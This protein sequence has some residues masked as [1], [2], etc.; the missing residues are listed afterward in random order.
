MSRAIAL[1][2]WG[3]CPAHSFYNATFRQVNS[4]SVFFKPRLLRRSLF[5]A[6]YFGQESSI[7]LR[8]VSRSIEPLT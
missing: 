4:E 8:A 6:I 5:Q 1:Y 7:C 3:F 2:L